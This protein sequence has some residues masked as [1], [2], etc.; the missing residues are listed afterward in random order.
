MSRNQRRK[1]RAKAAN[2]QRANRNGDRNDTRG[3][4]AEAVHLRPST[5]TKSALRTTE[6]IAYAA[7]VLGVVI[8]ALAV[9]ADGRGGDDP[10]GAESAL[11]Y[12]AF[13]TIGYL[14]ARGLAKSG[15]HE[16]RIER[17]TD[18]DTDTDTARTGIVHDADPRDDEQLGDDDERVDD[19]QR[20][21]DDD[22]AETAV[23]PSDRDQRPA[24]QDVDVRP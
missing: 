4:S 18:T 16:Y 2:S 9:D 24:A 22:T 6:F 19:D 5:E 14:V 7:A 12:I 17:D 13:L 23:V 3:P 21:G 15:S 10:F 20:L 11:R 8:T 1:K